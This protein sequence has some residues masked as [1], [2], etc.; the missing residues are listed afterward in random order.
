MWQYALQL[1]LFP[2]SVADAEVAWYLSHANRFGVPLDSRSAMVK[3]DWLSWA[4][5]FATKQADAQHLLDYIYTFADQSPS[6][7]PF[8][9]WF[10]SSPLNSPHTSHSRTHS[11]TG[12]IH[13]GTRHTCTAQREAEGQGRRLSI[14]RASCS[15]PA[16]CVLVCAVACRCRTTN[17]MIGFTARPVMGGLYART[18]VQQVQAEQATAQTQ[19]LQM[20]L[21]KQGDRHALL[22][23]ALHRM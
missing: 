14:S 4:A 2:Q 9:D 11:L 19:P 20:A 10:N 15:R 21:H 13:T 22:K 8:S 5:A 23:E 18:L 6:R 12:R 16:D 3:C 1:D 7:S 17:R